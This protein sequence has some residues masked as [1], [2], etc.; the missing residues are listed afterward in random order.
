MWAC[1]RG[2]PMPGPRRL[3]GPLRCSASTHAKCWP[4]SVSHPSRSV[5]ST[6]PER[7]VAR[8][9]TCRSTKI[10]SPDMDI[11]SVVDQRRSVRGFLADPVERDV[12]ERVL[13]AACRAPSGG[14]LQP[15]HLYVLT[16]DPLRALVEEIRGTTNN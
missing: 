9:T 15:W 7:S 1:R 8:P 14:N 10:S 3:V 5:P 16:G 4:K 6:R 11:Y 13:S 2:S 12:I